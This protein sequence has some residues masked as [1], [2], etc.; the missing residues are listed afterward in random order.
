MIGD[1]HEEAWQSGFAEGKAKGIEEIAAA[2][3]EYFLRPCHNTL[4]RLQNLAKEPVK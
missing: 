2:V 3:R 1:P 4:T